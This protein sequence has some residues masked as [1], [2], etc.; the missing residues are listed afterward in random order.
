MA[1]SKKTEFPYRKSDDKA[2]ADGQQVAR[3]RYHREVDAAARSLLEDMDKGLSGSDLEEALEQSIDEG[4]ESANTYT[5]DSLEIIMYSDRWTAMG[6]AI[7]EGIAS[8][9]GVTDVSDA[10]SKIAFWAYRQDLREQVEAHKSDYFGSD[11]EENPSPSNQ[12]GYT[13]RMIRDDKATIR[14]LVAIDRAEGTL[15][16]GHGLQPIRDSLSA[17]RAGDLAVSQA[18]HRL[19]DIAGI[20]PAVVYRD[21]ME[22]NESE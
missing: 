17:W 15:P 16:R 22:H 20:D 14:K 8:F 10:V 18:W 6:D 1:K 4:A 7:D 19:R 9:E 2:L 5:R 13:D 11:E 21:A 12:R 3:A